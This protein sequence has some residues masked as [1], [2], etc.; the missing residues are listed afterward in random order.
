MPGE[1]GEIG[2]NGGT[3]SGTGSGGEGNPPAGGNT[4]PAG[5][6]PPANS[7]GAGS[8]PDP[9][10]GT[11]SQSGRTDTDAI[12]AQLAELRRENAARRK[13][14]TE[15]EKELNA[16]KQAQM[17]DAEKRE[18]RIKELEA[19]NQ[20]LQ[21]ETRKTNAMAAA[22]RAGSIDPEAVAA[23]IPQDADDLPKA[24]EE[25]KKARPHLFRTGAPSGSAD[26]GSGNQ[27]G[28]GSA[29]ANSP[30]QKM[31]DYIRGARR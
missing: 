6:T 19:E 22:L 21:R 28:G 16:H 17:S 24:V 30:N 20:T 3:G 11:G 5:G 9:E 26:G 10:Q 15:L 29:N 12:N 7:Q 18:A 31:N 4:P 25:M 8:P 2:G 13:R 14:E 27:N 23:L 1:N